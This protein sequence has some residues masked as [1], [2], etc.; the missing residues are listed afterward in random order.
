MSISRRKLIKA[1]GLVVPAPYL[2]LPRKGLAQLGPGPLMVASGGLQPLLSVAVVATIGPSGN[3]SGTTFSGVNFGSAFAGRYLLACTGGSTGHGQ[4]ASVAL[5]IGGVSATQIITIGT[6]AVAIDTFAGIFLALVPSGTSGNIVVTLVANCGIT[7]YALKALHS[8][9]ADATATG[10]TSASINAVNSGAVFG[11]AVS[12]GSGAVGSWTGLTLDFNPGLST[13]IAT[14][15]AHA[16]SLPGGSLAVTASI[17][18]TIRS[19]LL[20]LASFH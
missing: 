6:A 8:A 18:G 3:T 10:T 1:L 12:N 7:L 17:S 2:I 16:S 20:A 15:Q 11:A 4:A 19:P 13:S 9:T 14:S 5:T